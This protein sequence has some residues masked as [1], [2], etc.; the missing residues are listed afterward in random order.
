MLVEL[1]QCDKI[2][3]EGWVVGYEW[4]TCRDMTHKI[5][6]IVHYSIDLLPFLLEGPLRF[7]FCAAHTKHA[8]RT[9]WC[10]T[11]LVQNYTVSNNWKTTRLGHGNQ[12]RLY[13]QRE[14][15]RPV[16]GFVLL[17]FPDTEVE[18]ILLALGKGRI[19]QEPVKLCR[20]LP[21]STA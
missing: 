2:T 21:A 16:S 5:F 17:Q 3:S 4:N 10:R 20:C 12:T 7:I 18:W 6:R 8:C 9:E 13:K 19:W 11:F 14:S 1:T 15:R